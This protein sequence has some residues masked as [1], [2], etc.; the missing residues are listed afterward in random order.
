MSILSFV[1]EKQPAI[2][3]TVVSASVAN[4]MH[5]IGV[6]AVS[7]FFELA[8]WRAV[9]LGGDAPASAIAEA[10]ESFDASLLLLSAALST[11]LNAI[12]ETIKAIQDSGS[13]CKI[14]VGGAA[15]LDAPEIWRK[16]GADGYASS[17]ANA[18]ETGRR[19]VS[20]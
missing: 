15:F 2:G 3:I 17:P 14:L 5:D 7:D 1:H 4:N 11:Q 8:G 20:T 6:R 10:V 9:C 13:E 19:L 18:L 12:R 16:L